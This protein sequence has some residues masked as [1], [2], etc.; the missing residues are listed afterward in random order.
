MKQRNNNGVV[1]NTTV[2][3]VP[4]GGLSSY[5]QELGSWYTCKDKISLASLYVKDPLMVSV[6]M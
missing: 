6:R 3:L 5:Q 1:P 4:C 2:R